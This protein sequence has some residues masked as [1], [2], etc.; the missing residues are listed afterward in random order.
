M[1]PHCPQRSLRL[2]NWPETLA[3]GRFPGTASSLIGPKYHLFNRYLDP[4]IGTRK[5]VENR[6]GC[7]IRMLVLLAVAPEPVKWLH[8]LRYFCVCMA[9][10]A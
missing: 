7:N 4:W 2:H 3:S 5:N 1:A 9:V 10:I 8:P 6:A